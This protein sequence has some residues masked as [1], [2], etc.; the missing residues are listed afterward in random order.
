MV[1]RNGIE[2]LDPSVLDLMNAV[3]TVDPDNAVD[4]IAG[5]V[6]FEQ[7]GQVWALARSPNG[8]SL[9]SYIEEHADR[10]VANVQRCLLARRR[11]TDLLGTE[12][13]VSDSI[14]T[15]LAVVVGMA[16]CMPRSPFR[17]LMQSML[18][19]VL[20]MWKA[21]A[22]NFGAAGDLLRALKGRRWSGDTDVT[23]RKEAVQEALIESIREGAYSGDLH[24]SQ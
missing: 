9:V 5:A 19:H 6:H 24:R 23:R 7:I 22:P 18:D 1:E 20:Q 8:R 16:D 13:Y 10:L 3:V 15:R 4:L 17:A 11:T 2:V 12:L 21:G 14:E